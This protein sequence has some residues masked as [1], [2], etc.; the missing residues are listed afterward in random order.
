MFVFSHSVTLSPQ[1]LQGLQNSINDGVAV[2]FFTKKVSYVP[3]IPSRLHDVEEAS[4]KYPDPKQLSGSNII[5]AMGTDGNTSDTL[6][7]RD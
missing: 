5:T 6:Q 1:D 7:V 2:S 3:T 4:T